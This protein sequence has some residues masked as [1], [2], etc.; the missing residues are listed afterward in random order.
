MKLSEKEYAGGGRHQGPRIMEDL[1]SSQSYRN[2]TFEDDP[3]TSENFGH[4][5]CQEM[6]RISENIC[7]N[8]SLEDE[9]TLYNNEEDVEETEY[10]VEEDHPSSIYFEI[11]EEDSANPLYIALNNEEEED[12]I[13]TP[14]IDEPEEY[15]GSKEQPQ[16]TLF[17][18]EESDLEEILE[19][20]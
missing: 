4:T 18:A 17:E 5:L 14:D 16:L 11:E 10:M 6:A 9:A 19:A 12:I 3:T 8:R 20:A 15:E 7:F 2:E 13:Q 1:T